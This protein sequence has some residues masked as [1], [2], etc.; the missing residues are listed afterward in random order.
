M[1]SYMKRLTFSTKMLLFTMKKHIDKRNK[2]LKCI[3]KK[4][5][6]IDGGACK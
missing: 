3:C 5:D 4:F 6:V 2:S 1:K